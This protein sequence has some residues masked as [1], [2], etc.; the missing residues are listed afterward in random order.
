MST[1]GMSVTASRDLVD[2]LCGNHNISL[3][4][5]HD[6]DKAGFSIIGTLQRDTRRYSFRNNINVIDLGLRM[7]DID[8]LETEDVL[9]QSPDK[10]R[11]NLRVNGATEEEIGFLLNQRVELNAFASDDLIT[12]IEGKLGELGVAKVIPDE[13]CLAGAY[14]RALE[15]AFVQQ[16]IDEVIDEAEKL[17]EDAQV[18]KG[19]RAK[20]EERLDK[21]SAAT[22]DE[23]VRD[24]AIQGIDGDD[25]GDDE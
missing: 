18:P 21:D 11:L 15:Q 19:L 4:A 10:A 25:S 13:D 8:G 14:R 20:V 16:K 1:K 6:F 12:W 7:A 23:I 24:L 2:T 5:L 17:G 22:W 3:L 9:T